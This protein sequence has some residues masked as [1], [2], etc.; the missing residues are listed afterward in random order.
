MN[1]KEKQEVKEL[2]ELAADLAIARMRPRLLDKPH[3]ATWEICLLDKQLDPQIEA[4]Q[5]RVKALTG[6]YVTL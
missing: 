6:F 4:Y 2:L 5:A 1:A 3:W